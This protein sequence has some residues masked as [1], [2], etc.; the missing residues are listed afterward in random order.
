MV[1]NDLICESIIMEILNN[2]VCKKKS[3]NILVRFVMFSTFFV[4]DSILAVLTANFVIGGSS[5]L[6]SV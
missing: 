2:G 1:D 3:Q 5:C 6:I 4:A